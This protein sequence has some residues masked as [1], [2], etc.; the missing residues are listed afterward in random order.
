MTGK[1]W[2]R[3]ASA[4]VGPLSAILSPGHRLTSPN[5]RLS[6]EVKGRGGARGVIKDGGESERG[7]VCGGSDLSTG[8]L[9]SVF[10]GAVSTVPAT[11]A[12][13]NFWLLEPVEP[14][15][16]LRTGAQ[17]IGRAGGKSSVASSSSELSLAG[18]GEGGGEGGYKYRLGR[19]PEVVG[20]ARVL[21]TR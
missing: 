11:V 5:S 15:P 20:N 1:M 13:L 18:G 16:P 10:S 2:V 17:T 9:L 8:G 6:L 21:S 3:E 7:G 4:P 19:G 14:P 12:V